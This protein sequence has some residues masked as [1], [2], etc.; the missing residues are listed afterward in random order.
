MQFSSGP[1]GGHEWR[2]EDFSPPPVGAAPTAPLTHPVDAGGIS[3]GS[4][5]LPIVAQAQGVLSPAVSNSKL[6]GLTVKYKAGDI[7]GHDEF[8]FRFEAHAGKYAIAS[9]L[10]EGPPTRQQVF[11][12]HP[13]CQGSLR[14]DLSVTFSS[15][16]N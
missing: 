3:H 7:S 11:D 6:V 5:C 2:A 8:T 12:A 4:V 1:S 15:P 16:G 13:E 10:E 14:S 9:V